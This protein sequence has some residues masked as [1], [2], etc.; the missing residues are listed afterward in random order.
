VNAST[1]E[2]PGEPARH[3]PPAGRLPV[4]AHWL[5]LAAALAA[6]AWA[7]LQVGGELA[8]QTNQDHLRS[9]QEANMRAAR[10]A[11]E[12][13]RFDPARGVE[14]SLRNWLPHYTDG[15]IN[16]LWPRL[17]ATFAS[18]DDQAYFAAG[19]RWNTV[20]GAVFLGLAGLWL[21]RRWPLPAVLAFVLA[22]GLGA[23]LPRGPWF[24]PE[25]VYFALF[26]ASFAVALALLRRNPPWLYAVLGAVSGLAWLAKGSAQPLLLAF[27][28]ASG[29]RWLGA[30]WPGRR[31]SG[32]PPRSDWNPSAHFIGLALLAAAHL[33]VI[34]PRLSYAAE[35]YGRPLFSYPSVWM[36][37]DNFE[38]CYAWMGKHNTREKLAAVPPE[39]WPSARLWLAGHEPAEAWHRLADGT[40]LQVSRLLADNPDPRA[41]DGSPK[42]PWR[43]LLEYP[44]RVL[45]ALAALCAIPLAA[46]LALRRRDKLP[47]HRQ[48]PERGILMIFVAGTFAGYAL[49]H[50][51]YVPVGDG[52]RFMLALWPPLVFSL[53]AAAEGMAGRLRA[54]G[55]GQRWLAALRAG[56]WTL[57]AWLAWRLA[58]LIRHPV[59]A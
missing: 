18:D 55:E 29:L 41:R 10:V 57:A 4:L 39:Q 58:E 7:H 33:A 3:R 35:R 17:A 52:D 37:M 51:W 27:F 20:F 46:A 8:A 9:D 54:R 47:V 38:Q 23:W 6:Y 21:G 53:I 19:K 45:A 40:W 44:G 42:R 50:G 34:G 15:V 32:L 12:R 28:A 25:P 13:A 36:W 56:Q 1:S 49:L 59:F 14:G 22:A 5:V 48:E 30:V 24:Q 11:A 2:P 26:F 31:R 16:P 43:A